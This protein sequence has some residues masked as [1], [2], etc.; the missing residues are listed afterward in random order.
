M[1]KIISDY[2]TVCVYQKPSSRTS[3]MADVIKSLRYLHPLHL[4]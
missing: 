1:M 3:R 4:H 2:V